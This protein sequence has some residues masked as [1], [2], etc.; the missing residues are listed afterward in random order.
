[1]LRAGVA[2]ENAIASNAVPEEAIPYS[3]VDLNV[4]AVQLEDELIAQAPLVQAGLQLNQLMT[5]PSLFP[6]YTRA[7]MTQMLRVPGGLDIT[8]NVFGPILEEANARDPRVQQFI[9]Q[10]QQAVMQQQAALQQQAAQAQSGSFA[11]NDGG[12]PLQAGRSSATDISGLM[13][14]RPEMGWMAV[15][16]ISAGGGFTNKVLAD[17]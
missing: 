8:N 16:R 11:W 12:M 10:Q 14:S 9:A 5:D 2:G 17:F 6:E 15:D 1:M 4:F 13:A 7:Y 3:K